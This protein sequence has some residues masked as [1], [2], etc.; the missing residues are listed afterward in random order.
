MKFVETAPAAVVIPVHGGLALTV[1]CLD[2][3]RDCDPLPVMVV[4]VDDGSPDETSAHLATHY[5]DV[6][7]VRGDGNLWWGGAINAGCGYA[8]ERGARTLILLNND[9]IALSRNLLTELVRL[10]KERG[11][12]VGA[13]LLMWT[14]DG[15]RSILACGGDLDWRRGGTKLRDTGLPFSESDSVI[16]CA[17]LP[18][19]ALAFAGDTFRD[20]GGIDTHAFPQTRGDADFTLRARPLGH[21][22]G[23]SASCWIVNDRTQVP[24]SFDRRLS[25]GDLLR[26]LVARNSN[27]QVRSTLLFFTRHAP[28]RWL[29]PGLASF[30]ARYLYAWLKTRQIP[31]LYPRELPTK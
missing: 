29:L 10:V 22:C 17:W 25:I 26:G 1:Q 21:R 8:L 3:L 4:V 23:V 2:S 5:P 9:N 28:S 19:M 27:Y 24:L 7:V 11:G 30:Y 15:G 18:G 14:A 31:R 16:E 6:H 20:L 13:T 12:F